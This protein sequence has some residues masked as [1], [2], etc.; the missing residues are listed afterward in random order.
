MEKDWNPELYLRF[1]AQRTRPAI[2]LLSRIDGSSP[3]NVADLGC[4]P[5]NSTAILAERWPDANVTGVD[6]SPAMLE[7]AQKRLPSCRF[8]EADMAHWHA[9]VPFDLIFANASLQ[10]V[11]GHEMLIPRLVGQLSENGTLA[12]QM[13]DN[14]DEPTHVLMG[15]VARE[16]HWK[17]RIGDVSA[18]RTRLLPAGEYY[19]LLTGAGCRVDMWKTVYMHV[20]PS[21]DAIV[22]WLKS[23]GLRPFLEPLGEREQH[24][25]LNRYL[26]ALRRA[27]PV[28]QDKSV[29][30]PF[31][32]FF[33][34][35]TR[36]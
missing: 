12:V 6:S 21:V 20:M 32:R 24:E 19:D 15:K 35:A 26:T 18:V 30:L 17:D 14:L 36:G 22:E 2:E 23:T 9:D 29:L 1:E 27:Y 4:G 7:K 8:V 28:R 33:F 25:F 16:G 10:W 11:S 13:P 3:M 34:V 31:P 5:G